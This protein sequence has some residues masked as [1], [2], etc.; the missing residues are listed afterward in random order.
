MTPPPVDAA[1][2]ILAAMYSQTALLVQQQLRLSDAK[3]QLGASSNE[4]QAMQDIVATMEEDT[5]R[6]KQ[7]LGKFCYNVRW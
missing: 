2:A 1:M 6:L 4:R 3:Q 7:Y 5:A